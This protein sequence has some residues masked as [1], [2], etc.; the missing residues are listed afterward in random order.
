MMFTQSL[1][2]LPLHTSNLLP[3]TESQVFMER[4]EVYET[5][6]I[7][8]G[9]CQSERLSGFVQ[10]AFGC[11]PQMFYQNLLGEQHFYVKEAVTSEKTTGTLPLCFLQTCTTCS[12]TEL[13]FGVLCCHT[14]SVIMDVQCSGSS[15]G[16]TDLTTPFSPRMSSVLLDAHPQHLGRNVHY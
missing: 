7:D 4:K 12:L 5:L 13:L 16:S 15:S 8:S 2:G 6:E 14:D 1:L 10:S 11:V 9:S 3:V